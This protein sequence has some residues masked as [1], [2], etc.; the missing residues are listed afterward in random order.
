MQTVS[1]HTSRTTQWVRF[2]AA[3]PTL[4]SRVAIRADR[5]SGRCLLLYPERG[6]ELS[7]TAEAIVRRCTC[8][9]EIREIIDHLIDRYGSE[10]CDVIE[11]DVCAFLHSLMDRGLVHAR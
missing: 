7:D 8:A 10:H 6:L 1:N 4:D 3:R 5:R 11:D 2:L 9:Y